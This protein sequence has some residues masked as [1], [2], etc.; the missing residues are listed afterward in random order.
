M[1][2]TDT[3]IIYFNG[4]QF[5]TGEPAVSPRTVTDLAAEIL[6][7]PPKLAAVE[8]HVEEEARFAAFFGVDQTKL[9]D[10]GW[11]VIYGP[12]VAEEVRRALAPLAERR[13]QQ[14][15]ELFR[16][17]DYQKDE[18]LRDWY[19]RHDISA[20][21]FSPRKV[22]LYLLLVGEPTTIPFEF[23][24]LLNVEYSVGRV[25]FATPDEYYQYASSVLSYETDA[26]V[27]N[28]KEIAYWATRHPGDRPTE[29][30]STLLIGPLVNGDNDGSGDV[31]PP[32]H[33]AAGYRSRLLLGDKARRSALLDVLH[34]PHA[35]KP[36]DP[37][38]PAM[39]FTASHG[40][41]VSPVNPRQAA[42][43]GALLCQD[44]P[45]F[46]SPQPDKHLLTAEAIDDDAN[47]KGM[48][49]FHFACYSAGTPD[50]DQFLDDLS[51]AGN[52]SPP[53]PSPF[54]AALPRRLL[55]HPKG[56]ALAVIGHVDRAWGFSIQP[57][58]M[59]SSQ[60]GYFRECLCFVLGGCPVG[61]A[62]SMKIGR[63][64]SALS[65]LLLTAISP[66]ARPEEK[67]NDRELV[68]AWLERNDAQNYVLLGD[69]AARIR[70][71]LLA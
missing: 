58:G 61:L 27:A 19:R 18:Q 14:A 4:L 22:P 34:A 9:S 24:Y 2:G 1:N 68:K 55:S 45:G 33:E 31:N 53:A 49:A 63:R 26:A 7:R 66:T 67:L 54:V 51:G 30:S 38:P 37:R 36:V 23:Q 64:Y 28:C 6:K 41:S 32:L 46:G 35:P 47:V 70:N 25:A 42:Y 3:E 5:E 69:P 59:K 44:W 48:V 20:G 57:P 21:N 60:I 62:L 39:L 71:D 10:V 29:L 13:R 8:Q 52:A 43:N 11:G 56:A 17:L 15:G 12:G 50:V 16:E 65:V 40:M